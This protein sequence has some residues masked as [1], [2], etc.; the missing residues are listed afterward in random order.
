VAVAKGL[1]MPILL[2]NSLYVR[3][4]ELTDVV[5]LHSE[6]PLA[7][8]QST[9]IN[10]DADGDA[11]TAQ[12]IIAGQFDAADSAQPRKDSMTSGDGPSAPINKIID[13]RHEQL[14]SNRDNGAAEPA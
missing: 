1:T 12:S 9:A 2:G 11:R 10:R 13:T 8:R 4:P 5:T 3:H 6:R 14:A 7:E